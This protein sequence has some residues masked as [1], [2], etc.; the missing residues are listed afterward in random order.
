MNEGP[1]GSRSDP[2]Y[3]PSLGFDTFPFPEGLTPDIPATK[4][5]NDPRSHAIAAA[6]KILNDRR[7][8]WLNPAEL[9]KRVPEVVPGFPY[10]LSR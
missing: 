5:A 6:A 2:Q 10:R 8:A 4:Y 9:V 1:T 3:T 7:E